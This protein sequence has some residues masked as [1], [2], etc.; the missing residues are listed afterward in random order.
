MRLQKQLLQIPPPGFRAYFIVMDVNINEILKFV[1]KSIIPIILSF[2]VDCKCKVSM[3]LHSFVRRPT[4]LVV[5]LGA[6]TGGI[7]YLEA[8]G[9]SPIDTS[10]RD[11]K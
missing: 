4:L 8:V 7:R 2:P 9:N 3:S 1:V 10:I 11:K 5:I 6:K